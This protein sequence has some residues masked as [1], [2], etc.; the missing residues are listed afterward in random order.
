[1]FKIL[2]EGWDKSKTDFKGEVDGFNIQEIPAHPPLDFS[3]AFQDGGHDQCRSQF[4]LNNTCSDACSE[5]YLLW[6]G[7]IKL[8]QP[9]L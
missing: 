9:S 2:T 8:D 5:S 1:M 4:P 7:L 6:S 3:L